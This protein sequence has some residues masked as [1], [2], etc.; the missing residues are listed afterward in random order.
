IGLGHRRLSIVDVAHGQQPMASD[1]G[2]LT[3]V[4]NGE[5]FNHPTLTKELQATGVQY[6]THCDTETVLHIYAADGARTPER[7]RGMFS[8]AIWDRRR[9]E[10]FVARDRLGVKPLYYAVTDDGSL[11]F[12]SEIKAILT[13][14]AVRAALNPAV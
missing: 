12:A 4:Y 11:Y 7:L 5:V 1:D 6:R 8:F 13:S 9:R 10:L 3:I 2:A 14:G